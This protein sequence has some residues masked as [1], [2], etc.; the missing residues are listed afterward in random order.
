MARII[1]VNRYFFPDQSATSQILSD[2]AFHLTA[3]G[4]EVHVI[5]SR[6]LYDESRAGLPEREDITGIQVHRVASTRFGRG[7]LAGRAL[8]YLSFYRSVRVRLREMARA[9]DIVVVK[10][11]PPLLSVALASITRQRRAHLVNWMQDIYPE[12]GTILGVPLLRGPVASG[13]AA[14]RN[15][16]LREWDATVVVGETMARRIREFGVPAGRV[17]VINNWCDDENIRPAVADNDNPLRHAWHLTGKFVVGYSGNLGRAH[18]Y[19]TVLGAAEQLRDDP[20][21]AFLMIGGGNKFEELARAV[22]A[23]GLQKLFRFQP[24]QQ[25]DMLPV[26]LTVPDV[27]WLSLKPELEGLIVPS[28]FYSIAAAGKPIVMIGDEHG[29]IG[30]LIHQHRCGIV[31]APGASDLLSEALRRWSKEPHTIEGKGLCA[32]QMLEAKFTRAASLARWSGLIEQL[33][34]SRRADTS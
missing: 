12:T 31:V 2:L 29:E 28:K 7:M 16:N 27:H 30:R 22:K 34:Q 8:D 32:R 1:F 21:I 6:Q 18:D 13:L 33:E 9:G 25:R 24:Y 4:H 11:D 15:H 10:T 26:S 19:A 23:R 20:R 17:H 14:L 5:T 3:G